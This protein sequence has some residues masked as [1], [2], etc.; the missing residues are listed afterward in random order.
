MDSCGA[1]RTQIRSIQNLLQTLAFGA[2]KPAR[3]KFGGG[4]V[5]QNNDANLFV[6]KHASPTHRKTITGSLGGR[7][8][9]QQ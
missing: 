1:A 3:C 6:A 9:N 2:R 7:G 8:P 4:G 5:M